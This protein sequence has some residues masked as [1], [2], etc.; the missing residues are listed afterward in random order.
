VCLAG[1]QVSCDWRLVQELAR[2]SVLTLIAR[3]GGFERSAAWRTADVIVFDC[4]GCGGRIARPLGLVH[5]AFSGPIVLVDGDLSP[6][7]VAAAFRSGIKD[8]FAAP[9]DR[10]LLAERIRHLYLRHV[11]NGTSPTGFPANG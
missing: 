2:D 6:R 1:E 10:E 4:S 9:Y 5:R 7:Q 3:I 11:R 8:Y